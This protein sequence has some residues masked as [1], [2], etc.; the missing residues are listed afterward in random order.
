MSDMDDLY[1]S[2]QDEDNEVI[3]EQAREIAKMATVI[4]DMLATA[5]T[6]WES[7]SDEY[8]FACDAARKAVG[9]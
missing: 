8:R 2:P 5:H 1:G 9:Q 6:D 3:R 4:R 7:E